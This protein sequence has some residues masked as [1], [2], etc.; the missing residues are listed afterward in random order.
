LTRLVHAREAARGPAWDGVEPQAVASQL[1]PTQDARVFCTWLP[2]SKPLLREVAATRSVDQLAPENP[3]AAEMTRIRE[4]L[5]VIRMRVT[6]Q[7]PLS[8]HLLADIAALRQFIEQ[9]ASYLNTCHLAAL[10]TDETSPGQGR[11][12][13][14]LRDRW[15]AG[16]EHAAGREDTATSAWPLRPRPFIRSLPLDAKDERVIDVGEHR[17]HGQSYT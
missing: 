9:N 7:P 13:Q 6:R 16:K 15:A 4:T 1:K 2:E 11:W 17:Q 8:R 10:V 14:E 5:E 12:V 3:L